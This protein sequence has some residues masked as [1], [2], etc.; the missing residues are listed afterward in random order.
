MKQ[1]DL[2]IWSISFLKVTKAINVTRVQ[3]SHNNG[4]LFWRFSRTWSSA[5][6]STDPLNSKRA[7]VSWTVTVQ[8]ISGADGSILSG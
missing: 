6:P 7:Q 1:A 2:L 5:F 4:G 3:K 8:S